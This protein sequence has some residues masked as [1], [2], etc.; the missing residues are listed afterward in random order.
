MSSFSRGIADVKVTDG[1]NSPTPSHLI[2]E[3]PIKIVNLIFT[4]WNSCL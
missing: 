2:T 3:R 4:I 1:T